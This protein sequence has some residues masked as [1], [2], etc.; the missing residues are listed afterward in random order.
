MTRKEGDLILQ[1][2]AT[3]V[4]LI[5]KVFDK[6]ELEKFET[7]LQHKSNWYIIW[8]KKEVGFEQYSEHVH[9]TV[10]TTFHNFQLGGAYGT[11]ILQ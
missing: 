5:Q 10:I 3:D 7:D 1:D 6:R 11:C 4:H 8:Y 9:K 2:K